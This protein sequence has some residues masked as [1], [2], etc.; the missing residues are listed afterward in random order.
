MTPVPILG[1]PG[2]QYGM[3]LLDAVLLAVALSVAAPQ[4][5]TLRQ[6]LEKHRV[7]AAGLEDADRVITSYAVASD[8]N[9][10]GIAYY[11]QGAGDLLPEELRIRTLDRKTGNWR[12]KVLDQKV[13]D[14]GAALRIT[15]IHDSISA[16]KDN[17][18]LQINDNERDSA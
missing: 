6:E 13:L 5:T 9:W 12:Y 10:F 18:P 17:A 8:D 2:V 3:A 15:R 14:G 11:W 1:L 7:D 4:A 16:R